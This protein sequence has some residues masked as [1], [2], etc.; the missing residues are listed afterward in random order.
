MTNKE[1]MLELLNITEGAGNTRMAE[2]KYRAYRDAILKAIPPGDSGLQFKLLPAE[3][4]RHI[5]EEK[6]PQ[7]GSV[8]W[9]V[10]SVKLDMEAR[11]LLER[12]PKAKPQRLRLTAQGLALLETL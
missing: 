8:T 4:T 5:P 7:L 12:L 2:W 3:V 9:H 11:G 6:R 1:P 10:T